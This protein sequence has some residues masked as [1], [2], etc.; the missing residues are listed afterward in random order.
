MRRGASLLAA[1]ALA[2]AACGSGEAPDTPVACLSP[3]SVYLRA[4]ESAPGQV[5]LGG[6]T[7]IS[8]CLVEAQDPGQLASVGESMIAAATRLNQE[9]RHGGREQAMVEL[10]YLVGA[11]EEGASATGGIHSDLVRRINAAARYRPGGGAF[12]ASFE[13]AFGRGYA[14]A[15]EA[16]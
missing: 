1:V 9:V 5:L 15:R 6:S 11:V 3:A 7:Q 2:A 13:S 10:G 16:G 4:L 14:A 12:A 8:D